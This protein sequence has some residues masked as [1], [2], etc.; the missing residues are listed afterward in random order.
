MLTAQIQQAVGLIKV[1]GRFTFQEYEAFK[2]CSKEVLEEAR[3]KEIGVD[4]S[5]ATY[6]DSNALSMLISLKNRAQ[7]RNLGL[8]LLRPSSAVRT[9]LEMVQFEKIFLIV[10]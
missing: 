3:V 9:I 7:T 1:D 2:S 10:E 6:L 8:K 4:L 5:G